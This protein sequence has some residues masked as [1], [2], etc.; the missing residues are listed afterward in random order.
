MPPKDRVAERS[1]KTEKSYVTQTIRVKAVSLQFQSR[2]STRRLQAGRAESCRTLQATAADYARFVEAVFAPGATAAQKPP[3][4]GCCRTS[5]SIVPTSW[6]SR[7]KE[8]S[9]A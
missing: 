2:L 7:R 1:G 6:R 3:I 8:R 5:N 9:R 4:H